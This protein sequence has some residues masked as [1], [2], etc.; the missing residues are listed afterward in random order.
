MERYNHI[1]SIITPFL[2]DSPEGLTIKDLAKKSG[3]HRNVL[4]KY[5]KIFQAQGKVDI[6]EIGTAHYIRQSNRVPAEVFH[7]YANEPVIILDRHLA[8]VTRNT[9]AEEI[10]LGKDDITGKPFT[11]QDSLM[12][13][14]GED[15]QK[16]LVKAIRGIP[17]EFSLPLKTDPGN[18]VQ[19]RT[20]YC[21][22]VVL[23][24]GSPGAALLVKDTH[25]HQDGHKNDSTIHSHQAPFHEHILFMVKFSKTGMITGMNQPF[26]THLG[27][28]LTQNNNY[29]YPGFISRYPEEEYDAFF[30]HLTQIRTSQDLIQ[31]DIRR[32]LATGKQSTE[33]WNIWGTFENGNLIEYL[34]TGLDITSIILP[35]KNETHR[36][37][38]NHPYS[39]EHSDSLTESDPG[40]SPVQSSMYRYGSLWPRN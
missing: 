6:T 9:P 26:A 37:P 34:G 23:D 22:P 20:T 17:S 10:L 11:Y 36:K 21:I 14:F 35:E 28:D 2:S 1:Y 13:V 5:L 32:L 8:M 27:Y 15:I 38:Y 29:D 24:D 3:L 25:D 33:R 19:G 31:V 18:S 4:A 39:E 40:V 16:G 30:E 12:E 7:K